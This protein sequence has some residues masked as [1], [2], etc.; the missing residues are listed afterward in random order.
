MG[1][2]TLPCPNC[3]APISGSISGLF[4]KRLVAPNHCKSCGCRLVTTCEACSKPQVEF[5]PFCAH[6]GQPIYGAMNGTNTGL[7][8]ANVSSPPLK[9]LDKRQRRLLDEL[10]A[11]TEQ[12]APFLNELYLV[13]TRMNPV[14]Q[15]LFSFTSH[16][17][18]LT[19]NT[20]NPQRAQIVGE[21]IR[22]A[23]LD[24][25]EPELDQ[26]C[27]HFAETAAHMFLSI[28]D[29]L[30][31]CW[32]EHERF[33]TLGR[34]DDV[35][36]F[37]AERTRAAL[38]SSFVALISSHYQQLVA[39]YSR[40]A[41]IMNRQEGLF[42]LL[43]GFAAGFLG[44]Q[45]G[46]AGVELWGDWRAQNDQ[47]FVNSFGAAIDDFHA[48]ALRFT[49]NTVSAMR[50][51]AL[52]LVNEYVAAYHRIIEKLESATL[53]GLDLARVHR[54]LR[55]PHGQL[56]AGTRQLYEIVFTN[57]RNSGSP[58]KRN[59]TCAH[60]WACRPCQRSLGHLRSDSRALSRN[61]GGGNCLFIALDVVCKPRLAIAY[62]VKAQRATASIDGYD[63][64]ERAGSELS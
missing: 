53:L 51:I 6:C 32:P 45:A 30:Q 39:F 36:A 47:Q 61:I 23:A 49:E 2:V 55:T 54:E 62:L 20:A 33:L 41:E 43:V 12:L 15:R 28:R 31:R 58:A 42:D 17:E 50:P 35:A 18:R 7:A 56:D 10:K 8:P 13:L 3:A 37:A 60:C 5:A 29:D 14:N 38:R 48:S 11:D 44:G 4:S 22:S 52:Q 1:A 40:Y 34:V 46:V 64:L 24:Q 59:E 63:D 26:F 21:A 57:L 25:L 19:Q 9:K 16:F 27:G